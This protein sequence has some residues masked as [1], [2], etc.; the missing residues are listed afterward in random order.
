ML[1]LVLDTSFK[2]LTGRYNGHSLLP[3]N[4]VAVFNNKEKEF[5]NQL[6]NKAFRC[7]EL[8]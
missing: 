1:C 7:K 6:L 5:N 4:N 8:Y 2:F 3:L